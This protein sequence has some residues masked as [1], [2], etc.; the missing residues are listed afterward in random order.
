MKL[1]ACA[2]EGRKQPHLIHINCRHDL[3]DVMASGAPFA[4][5]LIKD[6]AKTVFTFFFFGFFFASLS[7]FLSGDGS[8]FLCSG[9]VCFAV[10]LCS[11]GGCSMRLFRM[12]IENNRL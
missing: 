9:S 4:R 2:G 12:V 3:F 7:H 6:S 10:R 1:R 5:L 11:E 8:L